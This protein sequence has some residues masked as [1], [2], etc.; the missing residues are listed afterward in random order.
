VSESLEEL[1]LQRELHR[2]HLERLDRE[3]AAL[4]AAASPEAEPPL[5]A[6]SGQDRSADEILDK[7]RQEPS[8]IIRRTKLGCIACFAAALA[9]LALLALAYYLHASSGRAHP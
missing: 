6:A 1:R 2:G 3:I 7:F 8:A 4:E 5:L 9:L